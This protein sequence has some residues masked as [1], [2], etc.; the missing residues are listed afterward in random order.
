MACKRVGIISFLSRVISISG[1]VSI[2]VFQR[3]Y[4][5]WRIANVLTLSLAFGEKGQG[6]KSVISLNALPHFYPE[7]LDRCDRPQTSLWIWSYNEKNIYHL[8]SARGSVHVVYTRMKSSLYIIPR[9]T[10]NPNFIQIRAADTVLWEQTYLLW[11]H[12]LT[13]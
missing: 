3:F 12:S 7:P 4:I 13:I 9:S 6:P 2:Y 11:T 1:I 10:Y 8:A 5:K